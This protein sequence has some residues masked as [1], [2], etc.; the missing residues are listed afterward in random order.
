MS[1]VT[2][3]NAIDKVVEE[4]RGKTENYIWNWWVG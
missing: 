3:A 1:S 4:W 2:V